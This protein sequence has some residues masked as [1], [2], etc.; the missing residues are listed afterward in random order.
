MVV[1]ELVASNV[2][3]E[4]CVCVVSVK[5]TNHCLWGGKWGVGGGRYSGSPFT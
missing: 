2:D 5:W 4:G 1:R 3:H